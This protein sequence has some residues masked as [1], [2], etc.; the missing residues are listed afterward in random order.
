MTLSTLNHHNLTV[1]TS[2]ERGIVKGIGTAAEEGELIGVLSKLSLTTEEE[3]EK[4]K[5]QDIY[6]GKR[7]KN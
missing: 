2:Q 3:I 4:I 7:E 6:Q 5:I 1:D